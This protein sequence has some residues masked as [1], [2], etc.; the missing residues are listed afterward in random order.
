ME[1]DVVL[2][3]AI[4]ACSLALKKGR[5]YGKGNLILKFM[6]SG[7]SKIQELSLQIHTKDTWGQEI[8]DPMK[9]T[10]RPK[11][12]RMVLRLMVGV[13]VES[14]EVELL[15]AELDGGAI[16]GPALT[17]LDSLGEE[18]AWGMKRQFH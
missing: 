3:G 18:I 4:P 2:R 11:H 7:Q 15:V 16:C 5:L 1:K 9:V 14:V 8:T 17:A 10:W 6:G 12:N 13:T